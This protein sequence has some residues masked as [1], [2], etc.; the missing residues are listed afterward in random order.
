M[1]FYDSVAKQ[2]ICQKMDSICDTTD[3]TF[4]RVEKTREVNQA[5]FNLAAEIIVNDGRWQWDDPNQTDYNRG[6]FTLVEGQQLY[7]LDTEYLMIEMLE[8]LNQD[9]NGYEKIFPIDALGL[10][11]MAPDQYF[12]TDSSGN[13]VKGKVTYYDKIGKHLR[14]YL[15]PTVDSHKLAAG[16]RITFKRNPK[17]FTVDSGTGADTTEPGLLGFH[18]ILA[19]MGSL[20]QLNKYHK[21]RVAW[22]VNEITIK[23]EGLLKMYRQ[24]AKDERRI[25]TMKKILYY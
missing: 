2:G 1:Q 7:S 11:D 23:K 15:A 6:T 25:I 18:D 10:G 21:D 20:D 13:P 16:A 8:I 24:R 22:A 17:T 5:M 14:F 19:F 4:P 9:G 3:T 12:G